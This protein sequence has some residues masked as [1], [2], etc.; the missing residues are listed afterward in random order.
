M[1]DIDHLAE[2]V[3]RRTKILAASDAYFDA[4][5]TLLPDHPNRVQAVNRL[6]ESTFW[7]LDLL[8]FEERSLNRIKQAE[9][10]PT[11]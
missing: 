4:L 5:I 9:A 6:L 10:G 11:P 1:A 2:L 7:A 8:N 3:A